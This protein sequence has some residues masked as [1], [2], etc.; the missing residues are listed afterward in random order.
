MFGNV[1]LNYDDTYFAKGNVRRE[2]SSRLADD[3]KW[4]LFYGVSA[5]MNLNKML[6]ISWIDQ[7]KPRFGFGK[8]GNIPF[9]NYLSKA[10]VRPGSQ[11]FYNGNFSTSGYI[12]VHQANPNLKGETSMDQNFGV[13]FG[14]F[15]YRLSGTVEIYKKISN[16]LIINSS[17]LYSFLPAPIWA[18]TGQLTNKGFELTLNYRIFT[19]AKFKWTTGFNLATFNTTIGS[20]LSSTDSFRIADPDPP[21]NCNVMMVSVQAGARV[22]SLSA[23]VFAGTDPSGNPTFEDVNNDGR[24]DFLTDVTTVGNGLPTL[25]YGWSHRLKFGRWGLDFSLRGAQGHSLVNSFRMALENA[26]QADVNIWNRV[27][28]EYWIAALRRS[29]YSSRYVEKANY[30]KLDHITFSFDV[31]KDESKGKVFFTAN[32]WLVLSKYSGVDPE[33]RYADPGSSSV[34]SLPARYLNPDP[35]APGIDRKATYWRTR[36]VTVGLNLTF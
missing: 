6:H 31:A 22:G 34:G 8:T 11:Y 15:N 28:T 5:G 10:L 25:T 2:G 19:S 16:D 35:L 4:R 33:V 13:D 26:S 9:A 36:S 17:P 29:E 27:Q 24:V 21:C 32:N 1:D 12:P 20:I 18:N 23:A 3:S 7:L 30:L 14:F